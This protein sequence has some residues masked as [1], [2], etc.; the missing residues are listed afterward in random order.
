M[1]YLSYYKNLS[2]SGGKKV[3][4]AEPIRRKRM[5]ELRAMDL[6]MVSMN[7]MRM[8]SVPMPFNSIRVLFR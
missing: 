2:P 6:N 8:L 1:S 4:T 7:S 5:N 3:W